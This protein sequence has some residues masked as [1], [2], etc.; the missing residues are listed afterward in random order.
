M[1]HGDHALESTFDFKFTTRR[2]STGVPFTLAGTPAI[3]AYPG[4]SVTQLTA[5]ITLTADFDTVTGLNNVRVVATAA[6]G[7]A[8]AT[9]YAMVITAGTVD[10]VSVVG[11]VI[12]HF[13]IEARS[14]LRPTVAGRTLGVSAA[15]KVDG[16]V[17]TDTVTTYTGNT[18]QTGDSFARIGATGS[19]LTSLATPAQVNAEVV[20]ALSVDTYTEPGQGA[21]AATA[22]LATKLSFLYKAWRNNKTQDATTFKLFADDAVT[23]DQKSTVSDDGTTATIGEIASGP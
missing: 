3:S 7:Y 21:P 11:E 20:D 5:G 22:S 12:G 19:G 23:V 8:T 4:N 13:S 2:F 10:G 6:N 15:N 14:A 16:V 18:V 9:N 17:L 1:Y